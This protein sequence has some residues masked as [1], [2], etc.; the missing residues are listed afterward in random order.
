MT[1]TSEYFIDAGNEALKMD[2]HPLFKY[3]TQSM[4]R[5]TWQ[6]EEQEKL[7]AAVQ[8]QSSE[9]ADMNINWDNIASLLK[10]RAPIECLMQYRNVC[11]TSIRHP[12]S[13]PWT[14]EEEVKLIE[15]SKKY[16]EHNWAQ[17]AL[18]LGTNRTPIECLK[19]YQVSQTYL[20]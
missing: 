16:D 8:T 20:D 2:L 10:N 4:A 9:D 1:F 7:I 15:L 18:E 14:G 13:S 17:I 5:K 6:Q 3:K 19:H 12:S 11:D